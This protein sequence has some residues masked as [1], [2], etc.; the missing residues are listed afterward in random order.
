MN[1]Y[2]QQCIELALD[3]INT[4]DVMAREPESLREPSQLRQFLSNHYINS[5]GAV[6][7]TELAA[8][9]Q[10]RDQLR[11]VVETD[12]E[13]LAVSLLNTLLS[14]LWVKLYLTGD[15]AHAWQVEFMPNA[16]TSSIRQ[17]TFQAALGLTCVFQ[18]YGKDRLRVCDASPCR[19]VFIDM[20]RNRSRRYCSEGCANRHNIAMY[21]QRQRSKH[22]Q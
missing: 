17:M 18:H 2:D 6:G 11:A 19:D 1:H 15:S 5:D 3:I 8:V 10:L 13:L 20:S 21:R 22:E 16:G 14:T 4:Y 9:Y 12:D 7:E